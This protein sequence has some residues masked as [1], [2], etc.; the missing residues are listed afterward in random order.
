MSIAIDLDTY[1][2][3]WTPNG[4]QTRSK[5]DLVTPALDLVRADGAMVFDH[6]GRAY[7]DWISGLCAI[8]LGHQHPA[9]E[10]AVRRQ[11]AVGTV[12]PLPTRLEAVVAERLCE[13][14]GWPEQVRWVK[15]GSEATAG[16]ML[17]ARQATGRRKILSIGY[18]GWHPSHLPG[19]EVQC[20]PAEVGAPWEWI[21]P[22]T[23]AVIIE[24]LRQG[25]EVGA[26]EAAWTM[27]RKA[28]VERIRRKAEAVGALVIMDEIVT[29]FRWAIGGATDFLGLPAPDLACFGKGMA[30]GYPV[31]A[32]VGSRNL[33]RHAEG[34]SSTFGGEAV[35]LAA[36]DATIG[37]YR[38][39]DVIE[40]IW[41]VG[42]DL[43]NGL[44][45][46][47]MIGYAAHPRFAD[48]T[49]AKYL[50]GLAHAHGVIFHPTG[51]NPTLA[52][53]RAG[54]VPPTIDNLTALMVEGKRDAV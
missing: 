43:V 19:P 9:V 48:P 2:A 26:V 3:R 4:S 41:A 46:E 53:F 14:L 20:L 37:V 52:H 47:R 13:V 27:G 10:E 32:I 17:I 23:A 40:S 33:L 49:T 45:P 30:N 21:D 8:T 18:H 11:L 54:A 24:V 12:F 34:V 50:S 6:T 22:D 35:G 1:L 29:G 16:A 51:F 36:C 7:Y 25:P 5:K 38:K 31:A 42:R 15:T 39:E 28:W 44:G